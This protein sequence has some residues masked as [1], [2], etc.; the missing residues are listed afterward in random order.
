MGFIK[1]RY[2][3]ENTRLV[4]DIMHQCEIKK[5]SGLL[6]LIDFEKAFDSVPWKFIYKV[7]H[8]FNYSNN[9]I[10]WLKLLNADV[11][12][13]VLQC[14]HMSEFFKI[15]RGCRQ[16]DPIATCK[17]LPCVQ[18]MYLMIM[19]NKD[20]RG[21]FVEGVEYRLSQFADD[22]TLLLYD[23]PLSLRAA[24]NTIKIFGS[25]SGLKINKDKTKIVWIGKKKHSR[26]TL[27]PEISLLWGDTDFDLLGI[28]FHVGLEKM[29]EL[30]YDICLNKI[31]KLISAWNKR[32]LTP[33]GKITVIKCLLLSNL[34]HLF[35]T[36]P[37]PGKC[38]LRKLEQLFYKFL[39]DGKPDKIKRA[40][41]CMPYH[42]GGLNMLNIRLFIGS[43][44]I[45]WMRQLYFCNDAP[46][47]NLFNYTITNILYLMDHGSSYT[48]HI[49]RNTS[50][51]FWKEVLTDWAEFQSMTIPDTL[52]A[53][54]WWNPNIFANSIY[55]KSWYKKGIK[56]VGDICNADS[57][58]KSEQD[59]CEQFDVKPVD[60]ITFHAL[61][62]S[63]N[64]FLRDQLDI[65]EHESNTRPYYP[66]SLRLLLKNTKG[67]TS[68][69]KVFNT[70]QTVFFNEKW[71][72][73][74]DIMLDQNFWKLAYQICFYTI[75]ENY[76]I[77]F[78]YR[79]LNRILGIKYIRKKMGL[80]SND[81]CSLCHKDTETL[82]HLFCSCEKSS[83][84]W[85][86]ISR[87]INNKTSIPIQ[88]D[89]LMIIIGYTNI[90][91]ISPTINLI[92]MITKNYLFHCSNKNVS[93]NIFSVIERIRQSYSYHLIISK[94]NMDQENY[95]KKW[96]MCRLLEFE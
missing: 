2:I 43:L 80:A 61:K 51:Q 56:I 74:L 10:A 26:E 45:S 5:I 3:G 55:I 20:I 71:S 89:P 86:E 68:I 60:F 54:L 23:K 48:K 34:T 78:Q 14:G 90:N 21:I 66:K 29:L 64:I 58:M 93:P 35:T 1:G 59:I 88:F 40:Q 11:E 73:D 84:L 28:K 77:Y 62:V 30:N 91:N 24:L 79:V 52:L 87:W 67:T 46:W 27:C 44:K 41:V 69:K 70:N 82:L 94:K 92:I 25:F 63:I 81:I 4:Y 50:S 38:F 12:L 76:L 47:L 57:T 72:R 7:F 17:F 75:Q 9:L 37:S 42:Q 15:G 95:V 19:T 13:T 53:P 18:I 32:Y 96:S 22:T 6:M 16:G 36:L 49:A 83:N 85:K 33:L 65:C 39:W 31:I 8:F